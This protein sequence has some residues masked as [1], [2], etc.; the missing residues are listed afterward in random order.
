VGQVGHFP[1]HHFVWIREFRSVAP[2][3]VMLPGSRPPEL[4]DALV[5][6]VLHQR[7]DTTVVP[8]F[9]LRVVRPWQTRI[10]QPLGHAPQGIPPRDSLEHL[11]DGLCPSFVFLV[12]E[13]PPAHTVVVLGINRLTRVSDHGWP[14]GVAILPTT[15]GRPL[16]S[17][18]GLLV[19]RRMVVGRVAQVP[20]PA[21]PSRVHVIVDGYEPDVVVHALTGKP[22]G[23]GAIPGKTRYFLTKDEIVFAR[24]DQLTDSV[25][26]W[27]GQD[28]AGHPL[29]AQFGNLYV[30]VSLVSQPSL[31]QG[32]LIRNAAGI[33]VVGRI[34]SVDDDV[35]PTTGAGHRQP[36]EHQ[37]EAV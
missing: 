34:A 23:F 24:P 32:K 11:L 12:S 21:R 25:D 19:R 30:A 4:L 5:H 1:T 3:A 15:L 17:G 29:I 2:G 37:P 28:L 26:A 13:W 22:V 20:F 10:R 9:F 36:S 31:A 16:D 14:H 27:P 8:G 18:R 33:L 35:I 7:L 6:G